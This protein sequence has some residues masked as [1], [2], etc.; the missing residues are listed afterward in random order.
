M[1]LEP[2]IEH[3]LS[4]QY[5][6]KYA[7]H[8]L[9]A[10]FPN[11][12]GHPLGRDEYMPVE[13]CG[14]IL[15]MGLALANSL[16]NGANTSVSETWQPMSGVPGPTSTVRASVRFLLAEKVVCPT[17]TMLTLGSR[18]VSKGLKN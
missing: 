11:A 8:D 10:H 3:M 7:M 15:I 18:K 2:L 6:N 16:K 9:G 12:T 14:N 17:L 4:G 5:P 1:G 13:E